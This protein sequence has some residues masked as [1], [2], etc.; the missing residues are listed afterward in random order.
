M[1]FAP[2][3]NG[4]GIARDNV[5]RAIRD[6][7]D[8]TLAHLP[9]DMSRVVYLSATRDY[10]TGEYHHEGLSQ[11]FGES[12]SQAALARSHESAFRALLHCDLETLVEQITAYMESTGAEKQRVLENWRQLEAY[13][14]LIPGNCDPLTADYFIANI[15]IALEVLKLDVQPARRN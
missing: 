14:M 1:P 9:T 15:R 4:S 2:S 11:R 7:E 12:A 6:L 13:R 8:R 5:D 10:N 3:A